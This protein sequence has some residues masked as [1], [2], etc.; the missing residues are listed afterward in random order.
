MSNHEL[1]HE[2]SAILKEKGI[3][4]PRW[5]MA[6]QIAIPEMENMKLRE[7]ADLF[8]HGTPAIKN[9]TE[10]EFEEWIRDEAENWGLT[11]PEYIDQIN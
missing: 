9:V 8:F 10:E 4:D 11:I 7:L 3:D 6:R 1:F 5:F 2:V